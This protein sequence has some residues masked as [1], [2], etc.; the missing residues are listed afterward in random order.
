MYNKSFEIYFYTGYM[1]KQFN[2]CIDKQMNAS[3]LDEG[4]SLYIRKTGE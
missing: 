1:F 4:T 3:L 2:E